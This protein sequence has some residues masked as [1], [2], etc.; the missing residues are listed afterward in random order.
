MKILQTIAVAFSL[1]SALPVPQFAWNA[2]NMRYAMAVFPLVGAV[3]GA[4]VWGWGAM[5]GAIGIGAVLR[6][7]GLVLLPLCITG[8]IHM[9]GFCDTT[10][11]LASHA[12]TARKLEILSDSHTGAFAV[13]GTVGYLL[14]FFA[15]ATE[16]VFS[17]KTLPCLALL[18]VCSRAA[19]G[20]AIASFP[21]AKNSGLARTFADA[22]A[23]RQVRGILA[24]VLL[25]A[26]AGLI[27]CGGVYGL[28]MLAA[29]GGMFWVYH[30]VAMRQFGGITGDLAGWFLQWCE[31]SMLAALV[32]AQKI[33]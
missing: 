17:A 21:C 30:R 23:K 8:G 1:F 9:D 28:C 19:S 7:A 31:L 29:G 33:T 25:L 6:G 11:A 22:A 3:C 14:A 16:L 2:K 12:E 32:A 18:F 27:F 26:G 10:D 24:A 15:L 5:C 20:L 4:A 13:I